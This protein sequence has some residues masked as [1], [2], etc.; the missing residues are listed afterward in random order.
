MCA[1]EAGLDAWS[2]VFAAYAFVLADKT[3]DDRGVV[4]AGGEQIS[5]LRMRE[6]TCVARLREDVATPRLRGG[7]GIRSG[8]I[9]ESRDG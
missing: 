1:Q 7:L 4:R 6:D 2:A 9:C 5:V 3:G 8:D